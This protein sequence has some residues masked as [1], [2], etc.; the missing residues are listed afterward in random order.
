M[1]ANEFN[2]EDKRAIAAAV[3]VAYLFLRDGGRLEG[4]SDIELAIF[5]ER[6]ENFIAMTMHDEPL[7]ISLLDQED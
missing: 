3:A 6:L 7:D 2:N 4:Q 5:N 1:T